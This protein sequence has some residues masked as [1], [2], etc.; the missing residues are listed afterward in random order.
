MRK[1]FDPCSESEVSTRFTQC[2]DCAGAALCKMGASRGWAGCE[3]R[4]AGAWGRRE[5][6]RRLEFPLAAARPWAGRRASGS[7]HTPRRVG[8]GKGAG[9]EGRPLA[10]A[11]SHEGSSPR[12]ARPAPAAALGD[13]PAGAARGSSSLSLSP[14]SVSPRLSRTPSLSLSQSPQLPSE[15]RQG[16]APRASPLRP[17]QG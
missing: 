16:S 14:V 2:L 17:L 15:M 13:G 5:E 6:Q 1:R 3:T 9:S 4:E 11:G 12:P 10:A 8:W 7:H